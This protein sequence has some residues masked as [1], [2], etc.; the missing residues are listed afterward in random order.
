V[1]V[2]LCF[3]RPLADLVKVDSQRFGKLREHMFFA[4]FIV[5]ELREVYIGGVAIVG[6]VLIV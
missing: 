3:F 4:G 2:L 1:P 6:V 5:Y